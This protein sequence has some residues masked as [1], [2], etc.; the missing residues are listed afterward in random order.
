[1]W[2]NRLPGVQAIIQSQQN[3][4]ADYDDDGF[5]LNRENRWPR[6]SSACLT[7]FHRALLLPL[8]NGLRIDP[9]PQCKNP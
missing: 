2:D 9:M 7:I 1:M 8:R 4:L 5:F 3:V 6:F